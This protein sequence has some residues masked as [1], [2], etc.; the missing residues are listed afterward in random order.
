MREVFFVRTL[1]LLLKQVND[2]LA[3][4][5]SAFSHGQHNSFAAVK[6]KQTSILRVFA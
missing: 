5:V 6:K 1:N 2:C 4:L 3:L